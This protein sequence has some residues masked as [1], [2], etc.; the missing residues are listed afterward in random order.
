V[1]S[2]DVACFSPDG[3]LLA[4][5]T[6][7]GLVRLFSVPAM[8]VLWQ[9]RIGEGAAKTM[10]FGEG[11]RSLIVADQSPRGRIAALALSNGRRTWAHDLAEDLGG[12]ASA[13]ADPAFARFSLP[14]AYRIAN[15]PQ[16]TVIANGV[17]GWTD[18]TGV[19]RNR[20]RIYCFHA[21]DGRAAWTF[22]ADGV[23]T[24]NV[25][26]FDVSPDGERIVAAVSAYGLTPPPG[27]FAYPPGSLLLLD[28]VTGALLDTVRIG[29]EGEQGPPTLWR[30]LAFGAN[31]Q[32]VLAG[33]LDGRLLLFDL[34][35]GREAFGAA[36]EIG[37]GISR[38]I[39]D[40]MVCAPISL[41]TG[42]RDGFA[43]T[44]AVS[45]V[46]G[47]R[48]VP[49]GALHPNQNTL[50]VIGMDGR[51]RRR[52]NPPFGK[53]DA[54]VTDREG[55]WVAV[56]IAPVTGNADSLAGIAWVDPSKQPSIPTPVAFLNLAGRPSLNPALS[57]AGD[58]V[59]VVERPLLLPD[60]VH[61]RGEYRVLIA[62]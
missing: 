12:N 17:H 39:G 29:P 58:F 11:G 31:G 51:V 15:T 5:G 38:P 30:A 37:L 53:I 26:W 52:W 49:F 4:V 44:A 3:T 54:L 10:T 9:S 8:G 6:E 18:E 60:A 36:T 32:R 47:A 61:V 27:G 57:P 19:R 25:A 21:E 55:T 33:W 1:S 59:G 14:A 22:P 13:G 2:E 41:A 7:D 45:R 40:M 24:A 46:P 62:N 16:G 42:I 23:L 50:F 34:G 56:A 28:A 35:G 43:L 48:G 20:S